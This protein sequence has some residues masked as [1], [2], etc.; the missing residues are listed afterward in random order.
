[1]QNISKG[2]TME[3]NFPCKVDDEFAQLAKFHFQVNNSIPVYCYPVCCSSSSSYKRELYT[4]HFFHLC[5]L[6]HHHHHHQDHL[7]GEP[8][9]GSWGSS[10]GGF[11]SEGNYTIFIIRYPRWLIS[12]A[13]II[14]DSI[15]SFGESPT[16]NDNYCRN[17]VNGP[18]VDLF[19][20]ATA[21]AQHCSTHLSWSGPRCFF[22]EIFLLCFQR[23]VLGIKDQT[24]K[25]RNTFVWHSCRL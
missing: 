5:P 2:P 18:V 4:L 3:M 21:L 7:L 24:H 23:H 17:Y 12:S 13:V 11:G 15:E 25:P 1:M 19:P 20:G 8:S 22:L 6:P 9:G 16:Q 10:T 14:I